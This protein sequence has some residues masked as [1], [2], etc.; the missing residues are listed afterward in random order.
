MS[1]AGSLSVLRPTLPYYLALT[2]YGLLRLKPDRFE[3]YPSL[4]VPPLARGMARAMFALD[5]PG[6]ELHLAELVKASTPIS[7]W[8]RPATRRRRTVC[9]RMA[10]CSEQ[11]LTQQPGKAALWRRQ[12]AWRWEGSLKGPARKRWL[13]KWR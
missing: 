3:L 12:M 9:G 2:R 5:S 4:A 6:G 7:S 8:G 13:D 11:P 10:R 1:F